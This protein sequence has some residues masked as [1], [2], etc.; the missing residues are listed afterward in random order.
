[1]SSH[2]GP[3]TSNGGSRISGIGIGG[4]SSSNGNRGGSNGTSSCGS[5]L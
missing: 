2:V 1:M 4:G 5:R 3:S